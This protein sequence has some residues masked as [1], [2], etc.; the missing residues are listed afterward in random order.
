M[1]MRPTKHKKIVIKLNDEKVTDVVTLEIELTKDLTSI[2]KDMHK[3]YGKGCD[4]E[5]CKSGTW[6]HYFANLFVIALQ[7]SVEIFIEE[8]MK[9]QFK[10]NTKITSN[11]MN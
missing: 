6:D 9:K 11:M 8:K 1:A 4:C 5:Q 2:V 10:G 3:E 7:E